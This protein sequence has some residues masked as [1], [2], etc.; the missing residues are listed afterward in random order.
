MYTATFRRIKS[1][2]TL[3]LLLQTTCTR[4]LKV[5]RVVGWC[6]IHYHDQVSTITNYS[7][8]ACLVLRVTL[9]NK[10]ATQASSTTTSTAYQ[11]DTSGGTLD[12]RG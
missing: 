6:E 11:A 4:Y 5:R 12:V 8:M 9:L 3:L 2:P 10:E 1:A 7:T